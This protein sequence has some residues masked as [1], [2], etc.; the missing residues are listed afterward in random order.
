[1][2]A[3]IAALFPDS[4]EDSA[5]GDIPKG[6]EIVSLKEEV[7]FMLG[8]DWGSDAPTSEATKAVLCIRGADIPDLQNAGTGK[9]P[10][11]FI[12]ASSLEKRQLIP[13]DI[14]IEISGG[15]P[16][17]STGRP[18][19]ITEEL[20]KAM[21]YPLVCSNF[22]RMLRPN[23]NVSPIYLYLWL[24]WIY[25]SNGFL[26]YENG[27]TGI[28]NLA[29][30]IFS[31]QK[32]LLLPPSEILNQFEHIVNPLYI[33]RSSYGTQSRTLA[34]IRDTLLPKL[35]SGEMRVKDAGKVVEASV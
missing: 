12:K 17:Q 4:F 8:G 32:R 13:G 27:T 35:L 20:L 24:R 1:M 14:V 26:E 31:E 6:W 7:A 9:M 21:P 15:S 22:C 19:L 2:N 11:R 10:L 3:E 16:T 5:I 18:V 33:A 25:M 28:K 30:N 34:S 23:S 29:L